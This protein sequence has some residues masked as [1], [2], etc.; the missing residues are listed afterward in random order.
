MRENEY[1]EWLNDFVK[2]VHD[3]ILNENGVYEK[4]FLAQT[5]Y[6]QA[7]MIVDAF[8]ELVDD[9][10]IYELPEELYNTFKENLRVVGQAIRSDELTPRKKIYFRECLENGEKAL[11]KVLVLK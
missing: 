2:K 11:S 6:D 3:G 1:Y 5:P 8:T 4:Y 7:K 10:E 9:Q